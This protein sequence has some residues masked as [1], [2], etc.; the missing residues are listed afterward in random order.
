MQGLVRII[1]EDEPLLP[2]NNLP[3]RSIGEIMG[4]LH[5][6][7]QTSEGQR[8][9]GLNGSQFRKWLEGKE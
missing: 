8:Q 6:V 2:M 4:K 9:I 1:V 5:A 7:L 3:N